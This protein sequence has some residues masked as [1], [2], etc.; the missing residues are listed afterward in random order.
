M[1]LFLILEK[2]Y[3]LFLFIKLR[4]ILN[5]S[6][7]K[8][9]IDSGKEGFCFSTFTE[10]SIAS[11]TYIY[12]ERYRYMLDR[13]IIQSITQFVAIKRSFILY[14]RKLFAPA[15]ELLIYDLF[16]NNM[17]SKYAHDVTI[18]EKYTNQNSTKINKQI[19]ATD[20]KKSLFINFGLC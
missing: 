12:I 11:N 16:R 10:F 1:S 13:Q 15:K 14:K 2:S 7:S 3:A 9:I 20:I 4:N 5:L 19:K 6:E 17:A 18:E 8:K